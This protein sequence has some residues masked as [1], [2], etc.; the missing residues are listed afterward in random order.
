M[1]SVQNDTVK[2][3]YGIRYARAARF[4]APVSE[5]FA[6][7]PNSEGSAGPM[8]PQI[9]GMLERLLGAA[10]MKFDEDCLFLNVFA[11]ADAAP[12]SNL[13]VLH[14]VH[15]GAYLNGAG[16]GPWY[17]ASRL[18]ARGFVVVTINYRLGAFG[19]LGG[20]N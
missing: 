6:G 4:E 12:G 5:P 16:S 3:Y 8:A 20:G 18:A 2:R 17:D 13:P 10:D 14:W 9:P 1:T 19:F 7:V 15:G 11:P